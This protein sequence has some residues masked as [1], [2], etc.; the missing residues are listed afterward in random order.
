L[1]KQVG[2]TASGGFGGKNGDNSGN[3]INGN[4][5]NGG[6]ATSCFDNVSMQRLCYR[7][8]TYE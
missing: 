3:S 2:G 5:G 4:A 6:V 1:I 8:A 7:Q